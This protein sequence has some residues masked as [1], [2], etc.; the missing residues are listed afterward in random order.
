VELPFIQKYEESVGEDEES[1]FGAGKVAQVVEELPNKH[2]AL[3]LNSNTT[4]NK[5]YYQ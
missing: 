5:K 4:K 1:Y 3:S 2:E